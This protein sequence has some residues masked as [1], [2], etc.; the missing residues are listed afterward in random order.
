MDVGGRGVGFTP[1]SRGALG[2][3]GPK[4]TE[5]VQF[6]AET[7]AGVS[8]DELDARMEAR[9]AAVAGAAVE[10]IEKLEERVAVVEAHSR[11]R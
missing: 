4:P 2:A 6:P 1:P 5:L 8:A 10:A 7:R 9:A 3:G 11:S